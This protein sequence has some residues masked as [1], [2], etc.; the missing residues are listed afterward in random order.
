M[1]NQYM[2][3]NNNISDFTYNL[4]S[5][6]D[7]ITNT[8]EV[9][10]FKAEI[11]ITLNYDHNNALEFFFHSFINQRKM[12]RQYVAETEYEEGLITEEL[13]DKIEKSCA[14]TLKKQNRNNM[15]D[16][17]I[18]L[19]DMIEKHYPEELEYMNNDDL[20]D[21]LGVSKYSIDKLFKK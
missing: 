15:R 6:N 4:Q 20:C 7:F 5:K 21:I 14:I 18:Y 11:N 17:L 3:V 10:K 13:F 16:K 1:F 19:Y 2:I 9:T 12:Y 8:V